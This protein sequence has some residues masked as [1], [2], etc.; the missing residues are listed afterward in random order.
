MNIY[1]INVCVPVYVSFFH[2]LDVKKMALVFFQVA[3]LEPT[4]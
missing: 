3:L 4:C 2:L 1:Y